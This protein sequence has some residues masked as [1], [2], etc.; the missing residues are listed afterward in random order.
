MAQYLNGESSSATSSEGEVDFDENG[1]FE[2]GGALL[3]AAEDWPDVTEE[4]QD[5]SIS[6]TPT[7][8]NDQGPAIMAARAYQQEMLAE[9][10][11]QNI[12]V[13]VRMFFFSGLVK[14]RAT[15]LSEANLPLLRWIQGVARLSCK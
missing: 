4:I 13:A 1:L 3:N 15:P 7:P 8:L 11:K 6:N 12:I 9:S 14:S 2:N 5:D 10:L